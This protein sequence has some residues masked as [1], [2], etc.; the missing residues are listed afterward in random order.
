M[1]STRI[2]GTVR[3]V[4]PGGLDFRVR[5]KGV[6]RLHCCKSGTSVPSHTA[7]TTHCL[8]SG[9]PKLKNWPFSSRPAVPAT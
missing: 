2:L 6:L 7:A 5:G 9:V 1:A 3:A 8:P 4:T